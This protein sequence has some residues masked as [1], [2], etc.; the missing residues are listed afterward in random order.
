M[1]PL[2]KITLLLLSPLLFAIFFHV[3]VINDIAMM[4]GQVAHL[5]AGY[6]YAFIII[7]V[8]KTGY[9]REIILA[10]I[11]AS[12]FLFLLDYL[13]GNKLEIHLEHQL[14]LFLA[15]LVG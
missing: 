11:L 14:G 8:F 1:N 3:F 4:R 7:F 2:L 9:R 10:I 13:A 5:F 6:F 12:G 15:F